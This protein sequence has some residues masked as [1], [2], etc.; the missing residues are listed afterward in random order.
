MNYQHSYYMH[1]CVIF[2]LSA[3]HG[4]SRSVVAVASR[5]RRRR[6]HSFTCRVFSVLAVFYIVLLSASSSAQSTYGADGTVIV[7]V[8]GCVCC[9]VQCV[10]VAG[11]FRSW[12][13]VISECEWAFVCA[14]HSNENAGKKLVFISNWFLCVFKTAK[15]NEL[16]ARFLC[17]EP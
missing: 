14:A 12:A 7:K 17:K 16:D 11:V 4:G 3:A 15:E 8:R 2:T 6:S 1:A 5:S 9:V 10:C 13:L